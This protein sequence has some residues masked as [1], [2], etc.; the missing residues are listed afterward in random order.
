V[1]QWGI[2]WCWVKISTVCTSNTKKG[3]YMRKMLYCSTVKTNVLEKQK[4]CRVIAWQKLF[5]ACIASHVPAS[6]SAVVQ[7]FLSVCFNIK[8]RRNFSIDL[9][10]PKR[11]L[12]N[13]WNLSKAEECKLSPAWHPPACPSLLS[14]K[15]NTVWSITFA[16]LIHLVPLLYLNSIE[17]LVP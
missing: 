4:S 10:Y 16:W 11:V 12:M 13:T 14:R 17:I 7:I 1:S 3:S 6:S 8:E 9:F 2:F 15:L 5:I